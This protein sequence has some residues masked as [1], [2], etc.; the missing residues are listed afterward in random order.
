MGGAAGV[1]EMVYQ[2]H[3]ALIATLRQ[4]RK[5]PA[6]L[7]SPYVGSVRRCGAGVSHVRTSMVA[8]PAVSED[9]LNAGCHW[10]YRGGGTGASADLWY[11]DDSV[12][13]FTGLAGSADDTGVATE[14]EKVLGDPERQSGRLATMR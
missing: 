9:P 12:R 4:A 6:E 1:G 11:C 5:E 10:L 3:S 14:T 7:L 8:S 2:Q 13:A